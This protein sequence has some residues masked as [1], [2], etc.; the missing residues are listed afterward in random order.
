MVVV[1]CQER[2][3]A[4]DVTLFAACRLAWTDSKISNHAKSVLELRE[5]WHT[6]RSDMQ[7]LHKRI[8]QSEYRKEATKGGA[9]PLSTLLSDE[10]TA[11]CCGRLCGCVWLCVNV[12]RGAGVVHVFRRGARRLWLSW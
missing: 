8:R 1:L 11:S 4:A 2:H 9:R 12:E 10:G 7:Q 3:R 5:G 6:G